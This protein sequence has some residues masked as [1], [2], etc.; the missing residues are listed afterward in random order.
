MRCA[1]DK[2]EVSPEEKMK[3]NGLVNGKVTEDISQGTHTKP[4]LYLLIV[5]KVKRSHTM[6]SA[7]PVIQKHDKRHSSGD[8][9]KA[10]KASS[11]HV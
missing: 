10:E 3:G 6:W 9:R 1:R 11:Q 4:R 7:S 8:D 2:K 5:D